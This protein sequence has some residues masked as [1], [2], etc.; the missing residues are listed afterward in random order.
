MGLGPFPSCP[1]Q[2]S[3]LE[4]KFYS[5]IVNVT[6]IVLYCIFPLWLLL[7]CPFPTLSYPLSYL[8]TRGPH[9]L[10]DPP[11]GKVSLQPPML[12]F[13]SFFLA[14]SLCLVISIFS[15]PKSL[16]PQ[17]VGLSC[18]NNTNRSLIKEERG[19]EKEEQTGRGEEKETGR[20]KKIGGLS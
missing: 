9:A 4:P 16:S 7:F 20:K 6:Y 13:F 10:P 2:K 11:H 17:S 5:N 1:Q 19:A 8:F 18:L 15:P 14:S 12:P 3:I